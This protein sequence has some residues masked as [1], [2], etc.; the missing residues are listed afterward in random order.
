MGLRACA[1]VVRLLALA[2]LI[3]QALQAR[4]WMGVRVPQLLFEPLYADAQYVRFDLP[5]VEGRQMIR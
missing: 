2:Q 4:D 5:Y 3:Q 1:Y